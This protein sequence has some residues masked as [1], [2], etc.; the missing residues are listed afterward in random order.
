[1]KQFYNVQSREIPWNHFDWEP[2]FVNIETAF[3]EKLF[4]SNLPL[5]YKQCFNFHGDLYSRVRGAH[6]I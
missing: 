3:F 6:K 1:M 2:R 5:Q 4:I